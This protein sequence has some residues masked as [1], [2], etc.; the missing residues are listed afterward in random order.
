VINKR[1][2]LIFRGAEIAMETPQADALWRN[3]R[4]ARWPGWA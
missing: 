4:K 3:I 1:T 2:Q